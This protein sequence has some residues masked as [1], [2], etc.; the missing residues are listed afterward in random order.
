M[1]LT[2]RGKQSVWFDLPRWGT[3]D[4]TLWCRS[5]FLRLSSPVSTTGDS[6]PVSTKTATQ[7][8][9]GAY[10]YTQ[11][12][13]TAGPSSTTLAQ[14]QLSFGSVSSVCQC[15]SG[16]SSNVSMCYQQAGISDVP[17]MLIWINDNSAD[18]VIETLLGQCSA[19]V[20][21]GGPTL[22]QHWLNVSCLL[23]TDEP[24]NIKRSTSVVCSLVN[25]C[26][27]LRSINSSIGK[28]KAGRP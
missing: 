4:K 3:S 19:S 1:N 25:Q 24:V 20:A 9:V 13:F 23:E 11:C 15:T 7:Q 5:H 6:S 26:L 21:N 17:Y 22:K 18:K 27:L 8:H 28:V 10:L 12:W 2:Q 14:L 16:L